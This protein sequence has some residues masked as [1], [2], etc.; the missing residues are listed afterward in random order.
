MRMGEAPVA[1]EQI[2]VS[3]IL[4]F[5][6]NV[7]GLFHFLKVYMSGH[8]ISDYTDILFAKIFL[9]FYICSVFI[10]LHFYP[11]TMHHNVFLLR[12]EK[13]NISLASD[14]II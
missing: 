13:R 7:F 3:E 2:K 4:S 6:V 12:K 9:N 5:I 8:G 10:L 1:P 14:F 11:D